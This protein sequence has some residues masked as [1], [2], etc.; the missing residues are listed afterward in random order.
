M[1]AVEKVPGQGDRVGGVWLLEE[2]ILL[3]SCSI[4][5]VVGTVVQR[6]QLHEVDE[7][8]YRCKRRRLPFSQERDR[9]WL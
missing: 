1:E 9:N 8:I 4:P 7:D 5:K 6:S 2:E 3:S